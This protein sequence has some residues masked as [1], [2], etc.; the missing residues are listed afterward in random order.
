MYGL[1]KLSIPD[2]SDEQK[3]E[4]TS[5][6]SKYLKA[7]SKY[8][9]L[10][11][12][13]ISTTFATF[14]IFASVMFVYQAVNIG[15]NEMLEVIS[16]RTILIVTPI[17]CTVNI[18]CLYLQAAFADEIY[19]KYCWCCGSCWNRCLRQKTEEAMKRKVA[20]SIGMSTVKDENHQTVATT[21]QDQTV[22]SSKSPT[23][24]DGGDMDQV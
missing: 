21:P 7:A 20:A 8:I 17:D 2:V 5:N 10:L 3:I 19:G 4:L 12:L 11:A 9:S 13:A 14:I 24:D 22:H 6:Q 15:D 23:V 18:I 1:A 16:L